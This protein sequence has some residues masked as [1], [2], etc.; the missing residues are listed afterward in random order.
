MR[1]L[2]F[3]RNHGFAGGINR[4]IAACDPAYE[5]VFLLNPDAV[6]EPDALARLGNALMNADAHCVAVAPKMLLASDPTVIDAIGN[7]INEKGEAFNIGLGQPDLGQYDTPASCFGPCF[8]AALF[9]RS[10][11]NSTRFA[12]ALPATNT[13]VVS[14]AATV[15]APVFDCALISNAPPSMWKRRCSVMASASVAWVALAMPRL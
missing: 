1:W 2:A 14:V 15:R 11:H 10:I 8:G 7:A 6:V 5:F 13:L 3:E 12:T 9:R 4:G